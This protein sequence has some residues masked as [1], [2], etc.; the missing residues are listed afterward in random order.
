V[1]TLPVRVAAAGYKFE[2][3]FAG[4]TLQHQAGALSMAGMPG[5]ILMVASSFW[6]ITVT[7]R[8]TST[9]RHT[10][11][12]LT[13]DIDVVLALRQG[14]QIIKASVAEFPGA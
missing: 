4:N 8:L 5:R 2:D 10:V 12:G 9:G 13:K 3:E 7:V 1:V 6:C 14:D 11:F